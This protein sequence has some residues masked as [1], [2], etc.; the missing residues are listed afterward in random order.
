MGQGSNINS[1]ISMFIYVGNLLIVIMCNTL[2]V[3]V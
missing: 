3:F 1:N 2:F